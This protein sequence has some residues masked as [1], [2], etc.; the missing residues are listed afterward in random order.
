MRYTGRKRQAALPGYTAPPGRWCAP[1]G[2]RGNAGRVR[3][4]GEPGHEVFFQVGLIPGQL[5]D[6]LNPAA[7]SAPPPGRRRAP[8]Y[9][10]AETD[11]GPGIAAHAS[12]ITSCWRRQRASR[13]Q[14]KP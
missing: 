12:K 6:A 13:R 2:V 11:E 8:G 7:S 9:A 14:G 3:D 5:R 1:A 4:G 10:R